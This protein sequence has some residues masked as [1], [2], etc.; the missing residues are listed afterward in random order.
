M[1]VLDLRDKTSGQRWQL[2]DT[3]MPIPHR[4]GL[5]A[6]Q[7]SR[8]EIAILGGYDPDRDETE[9]S[10]DDDSDAELDRNY[11]DVHIFN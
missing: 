10:Q 9:E 8:N 3:L 7:I 5:G 11:S 6:T 2:L 1:E 4:F